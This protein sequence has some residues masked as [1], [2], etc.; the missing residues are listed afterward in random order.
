LVVEQLI[1]DDHLLYNQRVLSFSPLSTEGYSHSFSQSLD[2][3]ISCKILRIFPSPV[4]QTLSCMCAQYWNYRSH[5]LID[6]RSKYN[7]KEIINKVQFLFCNQ[8]WYNMLWIFY[9]LDTL[10]SLIVVR[11]NNRTNSFTIYLSYGSITIDRMIYQSYWSITTDQ[12]IY[13]SYWSIRLS[14]DPIDL[15]RSIG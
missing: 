14:I 11:L 12:M 2:T 9:H 4:T 6:G 5:K 7:L 15:S 10:V 1:F 13:R 8:L 3:T